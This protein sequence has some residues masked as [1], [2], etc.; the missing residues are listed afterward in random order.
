MN[1][2]AGAGKKARIGRPEDVEGR[3]GDERE[4]GG[5]E[6][7]ESRS[8][9]LS[10]LL[11]RSAQKRHNPLTPLLCLRRPQVTDHKKIIKRLAVFDELVQPSTEMRAKSR[12]LRWK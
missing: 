10:P 7:Q 5:R 1:Y 8:S 4:G 6:R 2:A 9:S 12:F 3:R 11:R